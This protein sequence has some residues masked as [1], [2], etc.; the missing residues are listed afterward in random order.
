MKI[1]TE[2]WEMLSQI[3]TGT[4]VFAVDIK[5]LIAIGWNVDLE[6]S[7]AQQR[8]NMT[9]EE[10]LN[11][12]PNAYL[13]FKDMTVNFNYDDRAF[14]TLNENEK[15]FEDLFLLFKKKKMVLLSSPLQQG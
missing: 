8:Y 2:F 14:Q 10:L 9:R 1:K 6:I 4:T 11:K 5:E 12:F 13:E 3:A 7:E 15:L